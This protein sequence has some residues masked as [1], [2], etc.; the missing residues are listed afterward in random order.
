MR[1]LIKVNPAL[2]A[3]ILL[4]QGCMSPQRDMAR[5]LIP[6]PEEEPIYR[7]KAAEFVR[8]AQ[9]GEVDKMLEITSRLSRATQS[10]SLHTVYAQQVVPQ[11]EGAVVTWNQRSQGNIDEHNNA[12]LM[13]T[14]TAQGKKTFSFDIVVM[15]EDGKLVV[16]NIRKHR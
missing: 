5:F 1:S 9:A 7:E 12:G 3:I 10:D 4:L 11:F 6:G 2:L 8:Y 14:G 15:K 13:F 16:I